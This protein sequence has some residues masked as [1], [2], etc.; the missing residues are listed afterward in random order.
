LARAGVTPL[1]A[2]LCSGPA[3]AQAMSE[4]FAVPSAGDA[5][6][7]PASTGKCTDA[8]TLSTS[9]C[10]NQDKICALARQLAG[11]DWAANK[12]TTARASCQAAHD[13]CCSCM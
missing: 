8:C 6:C 10:G 3:C 13:H 7:H 9:I 11:D 4:P 2:A 12:C 5:A 1:A